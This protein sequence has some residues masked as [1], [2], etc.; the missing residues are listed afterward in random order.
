LIVRAPSYGHFILADSF[1]FL[2]LAAIDRVDKP[3]AIDSSIQDLGPIGRRGDVD[4]I[5]CAFGAN[6]LDFAAARVPGEALVFLIRQAAGD[7]IALIVR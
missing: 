4:T 3:A 7:E 6:R 2:S 1:H 5:G